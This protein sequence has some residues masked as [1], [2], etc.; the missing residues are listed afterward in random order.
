[1]RSI[2]QTPLVSILGHRLPK[3]G[4]EMA[5]WDL[6]GKREGKSLKQLFGGV[7]DKVEVGVFCRHS[8]HT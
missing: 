5:L 8:S 7:R 3:A 6:I 2:F 4:V 1:M